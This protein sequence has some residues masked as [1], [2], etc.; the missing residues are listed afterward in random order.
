[1]D[2]GHFIY[3]LGDGLGDGLWA[4]PGGEFYTPGDEF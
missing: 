1:M 4:P 2:S 3:E